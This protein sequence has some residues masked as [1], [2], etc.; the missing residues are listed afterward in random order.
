[1]IDN[2]M[3]DSEDGEF[4]DYLSPNRTNPR[5]WTQAEPLWVTAT[6]LNL[7]VG[8]RHWD[9]CQVDFNA[10]K[11]AKCL[12]SS[13]HPSRDQVNTIKQLRKDILTF[14]RGSL[15]L[16]MYQYDAI[17]FYGEERTRFCLRERNSVVIDQFRIQLTQYSPQAL[18]PDSSTR[19][20]RK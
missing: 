5:W 17:D 6:R 10:T 9:G 15:D 2:Q 4:F 1:M 3:F 20:S 8:M 13:P 14:R 19:L 16:A 11:R 7:R 12:L 18:P